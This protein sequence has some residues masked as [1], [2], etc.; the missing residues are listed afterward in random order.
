[1]EKA[2]FVRKAPGYYVAGVR[3]PG[4][5]PTLV[6]AAGSNLDL[7]A[8]MDH[9]RHP[10]IGSGGAAQCANDVANLAALSTVRCNAARRARSAVIASLAHVC[11]TATSVSVE[12]RVRLRCVKTCPR[13]APSSH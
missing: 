8:P 12:V 9:V 6:S 5:R 1:M 10:N 13:A 2:E 11:E 3:A 7:T 4:R